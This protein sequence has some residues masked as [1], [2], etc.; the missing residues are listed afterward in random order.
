[1]IIKENSISEHIAIAASVAIPK[2]DWQW[3]HRYVG[4]DS[5]KYGSVDHLRFPNACR[6]ALE[7]LARTFVPPSGCFPD[8][9]YHA[10]GM[11]MIPPEGWLSGHYDAEYHPLYNWQRV[12]SLVWFA[13]E[14]WEDNWGGKLVIKGKEITPKFNTCVYFDTKDCWHE[15]TRITGPEFRKTLAIFYWK[16]VDSVDKKA[17]RK[18]NFEK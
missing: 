17:S 12:G 1:M 8:M 6:I 15:V 18:A 11:H 14:K 13:N 4:K 9:D 7:E 5:V 2:E 10:G 16:V 3:W